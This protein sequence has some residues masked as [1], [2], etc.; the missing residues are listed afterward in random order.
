MLST[1]KS[2]ESTSCF[3]KGKLCI[4]SSKETPVTDAVFQSYPHA[5]HIR[6]FCLTTL[7]HEGQSHAVFG[8]KTTSATYLGAVSIK[9]ISLEDTFVLRV[10]TL[11]RVA[12]KTNPSQSNAHEVETWRGHCG[13]PWTTSNADCSPSYET[14]NK[15]SDID[16]HESVTRKQ[17]P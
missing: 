10:H 5:L 2:T 1:W 13:S 14:L 7:P 9:E 16:T 4:T 11:S 3:A 12:S 6:F 15:G 8:A 17:D